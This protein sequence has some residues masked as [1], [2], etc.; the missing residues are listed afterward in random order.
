MTSIII[1]AAGE[2]GGTEFY[3]TCKKPM[4]LL[5]MDGF[6]LN[7]KTYGNAIAQANKPHLDEIFRKYPM[8][9]LDACGEAVGLPAGQMGNSEVGHLNIGAGRVIYQD[10]TRITKDAESGAMFKNPVLLNAMETAKANRGA[11]HI[12]GL[13]SL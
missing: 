3:M 11:L 4:M 1:C 12:F 9:R 8:T 7:E 13:L 2:G 10:L 6:G 5:I